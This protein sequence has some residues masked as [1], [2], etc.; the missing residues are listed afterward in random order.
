MT[1]IPAANAAP[2]PPE[3]PPTDL[4]KFQGFS[5]RPQSRLFESKLKA[6]CGKFV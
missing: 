6:S 5:A 3:L 1:E 2:Y 4:F